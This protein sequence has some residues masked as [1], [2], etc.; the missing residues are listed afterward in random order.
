MKTRTAYLCQECGHQTSKWLGKCPQCEKWNSFLEEIITKGPSRSSKGLNATPLKPAP[1]SQTQHQESNRYPVGLSEIDR[2]LGGGI[3]PGS[4]ILLSGEPGIGKSTL[5]LQICAQLTHQTKQILYISGEESIQQISGR[6]AR[7]NLASENLQLLNETHLETILATIQQEK[8]SLVI[9]DSIQV[10]YSNNLPSQA[11]SISQVR[12]ATEA[13]MEFAK[14]NQ[15]P[16]ILIGHVTKE[17]NLAGP[18]V[19]EH[20]VDTVLF[21]EGDRYQNFRLLRCLKNRFG[22]TNEVGVLEMTEKGLIEVKNPSATFLSGRQENAIGSTVT[23]TIEGTRPFLIEVQALTNLSPFGYPKRTT[24]GYDLNRLQ[25]LVAVLQKH[26]GLNLSNQD[27]FVNVVGGFKL[28]ET[29]ADL[30]LALSIVS[31]YRKIVMPTE[32]CILGEVGLSGEIRPVTQLHK[33]LQE[34]SKLG[35]K[36]IILPATKD[37]PKIPGATLHPVRT[38]KEAIQIIA[39]E[40]IKVIRD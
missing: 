30:S 18:R 19:L 16:I 28:Q 39:T 1:L 27:V 36:Q 22:S 34:A 5:T 7:L 14:T 23:C 29:A 12:S 38:I 6:A 3:L 2:V 37:L 32:L 13:L 8:P 11:G 20:L 9:V 17:G 31:S 24:T 35:F 25:L 26:V 15:I 4:L 40:K 33:R 10:V 21:I